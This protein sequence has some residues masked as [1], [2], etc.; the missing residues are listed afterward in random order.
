MK[1]KLNV[2]ELIERN[3]REEMPIIKLLK[4][5]K[6]KYIF[7]FGS[8]LA[9]RHGKG[10][11]LIAY[12]EYGAKYGK[13]GRKGKHGQSYAIPT[14]DSNLQPLPLSRIA[15]YVGQFIHYAANHKKLVF[16]VT[17]IGCGLA[18]YKPKQI[19]PMF[20][21]AGSNVLLP[22]EFARFTK[23]EKK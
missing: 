17:R 11:A 23:W 21:L 22:S 15:Y 19:A 2:Q 1:N 18:G 16:Y 4:K 14:K 8:N 7:V 13:K 12:Q 9:G 5:Q 10:A 3:L 6:V 20:K